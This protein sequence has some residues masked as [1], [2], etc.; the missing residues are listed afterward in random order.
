MYELVGP[1]IGAIAV[2]GIPLVAWLSRRSTREGR[3]LMRVE[4]LGT[5]HALMPDSA[6]KNSFAVYLVAAI[7]DLNSWLNPD[8]AKR[9]RLI[10]RIFGWTYALGV[11]AVLISIPA[12]N[13][14][15]K[16]WLPST[17]G[18]SIGTGIAA[19]TMGSSF[20]IERSARRK[21]ALARK[22]AEDAESQARMEALLRA[23]ESRAYVR[24][25]PSIG[26]L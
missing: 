11:I 7:S 6:E 20:L 26:H 4:R 21:A 23:P 8:N 2:I 22:R 10:R 5:A 16:P 9:R 13:D 14:E 25:S 19:I 18:I 17:L 12:V 24:D 15:S 1:V 3:L